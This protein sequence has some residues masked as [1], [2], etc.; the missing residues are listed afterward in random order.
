[1]QIGHLAQ[2]FQNGIDGGGF[3]CDLLRHIGLFTTSYVMKEFR[4]PYRGR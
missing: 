1:L 2:I 4:L 3:E